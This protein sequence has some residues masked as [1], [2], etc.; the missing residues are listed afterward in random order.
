M[1][2]YNIGDRVVVRSDMGVMLHHNPHYLYRMSSGVPGYVIVEG[3]LEFNGKTVTIAS[4]DDDYHCYRIVEDR[5]TT[6]RS[7]WLWTDEMFDGLAES[8]K[9]ICQDDLAD[10]LNM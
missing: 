6:V 3:M 8:G 10:L 4:Y 5:A 7:R 1:Y 2:Q 9:E